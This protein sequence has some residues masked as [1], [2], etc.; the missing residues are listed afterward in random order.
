MRVVGETGGV[1]RSLLT[2]QTIDVRTPQ[3]AALQR[4]LRPGRQPMRTAPP[5]WPSAPPRE[6]ERERGRGGVKPPRPS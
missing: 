1:P 5:T 6:P 4:H 2:E 3:W